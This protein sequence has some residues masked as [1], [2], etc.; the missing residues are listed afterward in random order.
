[1]R[2]YGKFDVAS[3][4]VSVFSQVTVKDHYV[5]GY[6][7]PLFT[8]ITVYDSNKDAKKP[9]LHQVY[10]LAIGGAAKILKNHA[11]QNVA[12]RVDIAGPVNTP[13]LSTWQAIGQFLENAFINAIIPGY[14]RQVAQARHA[15]S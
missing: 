8:D 4:R 9:I 14:D 10:E 12:T 13:N 7:K 15:P 2:A 1:L 11:S 5:N 6:V 3:G